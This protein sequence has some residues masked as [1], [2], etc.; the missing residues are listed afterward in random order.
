DRCVTRR[1]DR[2]CFRVRC[3]FPGEVAGV[4]FLERCVDVFEVEQNA[5][6]YPV[7]AANL[8]DAQHLEAERLGA[9]A[10]RYATSGEGEALAAGCDD[11]RLVVPSTD[12]DDGPQIRDL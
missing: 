11:D 10:A 2:P 4:E 6:C 5:C 9:L 1:N 8:D 7:V 3:R 12:I